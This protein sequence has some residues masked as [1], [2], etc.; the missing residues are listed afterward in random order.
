MAIV[1]VGAAGDVR[2]VFTKGRDTIMAGSAGTN[3]LRVIDSYYRFERD[4]AVAVF[5]DLGCLHVRRSFASRGRSVM[6]GY[7]VPGDARMVKCRG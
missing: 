2:C 4:G 5:A 6:A 7:A 3:N 1:T